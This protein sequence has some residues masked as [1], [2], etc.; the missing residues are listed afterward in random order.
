MEIS[1]AHEITVNS[2]S[3]TE[4]LIK[5]LIWVV[6]YGNSITLKCTKQEAR[7]QKGDD[8][9]EKHNKSYVISNA[10]GWRIFLSNA[11]SLKTQ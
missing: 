5:L 11:Y 4:A 3:T 2:K 1:L 6:E 10:L 8:V 9:M 7:E